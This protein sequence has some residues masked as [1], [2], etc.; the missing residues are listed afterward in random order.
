MVCNIL[1]IMQQCEIDIIII[2]VL[3]DMLTRT[4]N[5]MQLM[6]P[7]TCDVAVYRHSSPRAYGPQVLCL[8]GPRVLCLLTSN[9]PRRGVIANTYTACAIYVHAM[10]S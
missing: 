3:L 1:R 6:T 7:L 2:W 4:A 10:P 9:I 5:L 8:D